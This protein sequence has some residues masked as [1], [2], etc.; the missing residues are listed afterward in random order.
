MIHC[1]FENG[2][3]ANLRHL[4]VNGIIVKDDK[5]LLAKRGTVNSEPILEFGKWCLLVDL[6]K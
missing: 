2:N 3:K 6:W 4:T 5:I 1:E